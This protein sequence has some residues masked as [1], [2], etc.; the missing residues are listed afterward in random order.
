MLGWLDRMDRHVDD[1]GMNDTG[2]KLRPSELF[3]RQ[4]FIS[5]EPTEKGL[6]V[7]A[8]A[9]GPERILWA[10]DY[11]HH[12][13]FWGAAKDDQEDGTA[14]GPRSHDHGRG[15]QAVLQL[16]LIQRNRRGG[17]R[18]GHPT[19]ALALIS[20]STLPGPSF[21]VVGG[22]ERV[23]RGAKR[24][25]RITRVAHDDG[26]QVQLLQRLRQFEV[27]VALTGHDQRVDT[28]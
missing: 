23:L 5:F 12:D 22:C 11:P 6:K 3:H 17:R 14:A 28:G 9:I 27:G 4:C 10:S 7:V 13:G 20:V 25:S 24:V 2:L 16:S 26:A 18:Y 15:R 1:K 8:D 21:Q 19:E